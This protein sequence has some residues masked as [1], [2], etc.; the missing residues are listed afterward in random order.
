MTPPNLWKKLGTVA[1]ACNPS[2]GEEE[3]GG[4][5][6]SRDRHPSL[7]AKLQVSEKACGWHLRNNTKV[8]LWY[9]SIFV[10]TNK[11]TRNLAQT[12]DTLLDVIFKVSQSLCDF[13]VTLVLHVPPKILSRLGRQ[14]TPGT[15]W[16]P[17]SP[18]CTSTTQRAHTRPPVRRAGCQYFT[19]GFSTALC[20]NT[21]ARLLFFFFFMRHTEKGNYTPPHR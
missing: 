11:Q 15:L 1:Q 17:Q 20:P 2:T 8:D 4:P 16:V 21:W 19:D 3:T 10:Q 7:L 9:R 13:S 18:A 6:G 14:Q 5:L 12:L